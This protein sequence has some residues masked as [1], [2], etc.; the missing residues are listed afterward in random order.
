MKL[1][2]FRALRISALTGSPIGYEVLIRPA[3]ASAVSTAAATAAAAAAID[4]AAAQE[5]CAEA[6]EAAAT[7]AEEGRALFVC[8]APLLLQ[9]QQL[10][11]AF[12][13]FGPVEALYD[14]LTQQKIS[15]KSVA[16][17][18]LVHII[19]EEAAA[20]ARALA[21][22]VPLEWGPPK[23]GAKGAPK[24]G[25]PKEGQVDAFMQS[26]DLG[27]DL[28]KQ[29]RNKQIVDEDG[30]ILVQGPKNSAGEGETIKGFRR[31][32]TT[33]LLHAGEEKEE[34]AA[35]RAQKALQTLAEQV[36]KK[37]FRLT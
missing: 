32:E 21:A 19:Y 28:R 37:A 2:S 9:Q 15:K 23:V 4:G 35:A 8:N 27:K 20:A 11:Q 7:A 5:A 14:K 10:Q 24:K 22:A 30:F 34:D 3:E 17:V 29:Q 25:A 16:S 1:H 33:H 6:A 26:Y 18:R 12:A 31:A 36:K 13:A